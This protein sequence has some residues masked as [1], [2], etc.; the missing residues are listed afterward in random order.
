MFITV[1]DP[2]TDF[3]IDPWLERKL[4]RE[5]R[6]GEVF[7]GTYVYVPPGQ[8]A[9]RVY[10][11]WFDLKGTLEPTGTGIEAKSGYAF[12]PTTLSALGV[13]GITLKPLS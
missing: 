3:I 1:F 4:G 13:T 10:G 12:S 8:P 7:G 2:A 6:T 9:M 11:S 5:L